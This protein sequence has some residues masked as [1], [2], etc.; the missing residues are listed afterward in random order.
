MKTRT[1]AAR[2]RLALR[3]ASAYWRRSK[4]LEWRGDRDGAERLAARCCHWWSRAIRI[5]LGR[6][7]DVL[8]P[9]PGPLPVEGRGRRA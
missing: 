6:G 9:H 1:R 2:V 5:E 7:A 8:T 4:V 3:R